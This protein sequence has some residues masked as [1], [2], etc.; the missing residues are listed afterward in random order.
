[1][2]K[3]IQRVPYALIKK[4]LGKILLTFKE[5]QKI[6]CEKLCMRMPLVIY[7]CAADFSLLN[8]PKV[9]SLGRSKPATNS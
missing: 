1:M 6:L 8:L 7:N 5:I 9:K 3:P 4:K 2:Q